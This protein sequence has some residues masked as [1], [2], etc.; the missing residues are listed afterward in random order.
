MSQKTHWKKTDNPNYLGAYS[1]EDP[2]ES[3]I[4]TIASINPTETVYNPSTNSDETVFVISF[5]QASLKPMILNTTNKKAI[6]KATGSD[7]IE[8]WVGKSIE[9]FVTKVKAFGEMVDA[10]RVRPKAPKLK[11]PTL[12]PKHKKWKTVKTQLASGDLE[13][14]TVEQHFTVSKEMKE[15]LLDNE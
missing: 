4:G 5:K 14:S 1:F 12:T 8:D 2:R 7:F 10:V 13:M 9:L 3:K 11:K 6:A 15:R